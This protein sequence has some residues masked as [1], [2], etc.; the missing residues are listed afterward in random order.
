[1]RCVWGRGV[2]IEGYRQLSFGS[3]VAFAGVWREVDGGCFC[4]K[5]EPLSNEEVDTF[6]MDEVRSRETG[7]AAKVNK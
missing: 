3:T 7:N 2:V 6:L 5:V 4:N 1:M